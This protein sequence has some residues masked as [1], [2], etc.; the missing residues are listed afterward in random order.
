MSEL[1]GSAETMEQYLYDRHI[2]LAEAAE[3]VTGSLDSDPRLVFPAP[4]E[5]RANAP[6]PGYTDNQERLLREIAGRFGIGGETDIQAAADY[7][8]IEGG[9]P[10]KVQAEAA[11]AN[12]IG[13][14]VFAGSPNRRI[15]SDEASYMQQLLGQQ[16]PAATTEYEM[17]RQ[18][19]SVQP[20]FVPL[21][22]PLD[23]TWQTISSSLSKKPGN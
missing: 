7:E 5:V 23:I 12:P 19:A 17:V 10:W 4:S 11:I 13:S 3:V 18:I 15:G 22:E 16:E 1:S 14:K 6:D 21:D 20:G 8:L 2:W 9:K